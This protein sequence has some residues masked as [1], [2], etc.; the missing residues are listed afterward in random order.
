VCKWVG[1]WAGG[2]KEARD[3]AHERAYLHLLFKIN[4]RRRLCINSLLP[5]GIACHP[6]CIEELPTLPCPFAALARQLLSRLGSL[7]FKLLPALPA[8]RLDGS[9][10][11]GLPISSQARAFLLPNRALLRTLR[12]ELR[13][14]A[15]LLD[16]QGLQLFP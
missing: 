8:R 13:D 16:H 7:Q 1:G 12:L 10:H 14:L 9:F 4:P 3:R 5:G 11:G 2:A 6:L 15:I